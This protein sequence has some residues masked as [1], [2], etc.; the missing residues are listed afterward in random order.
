M[1]MQQDA[2]LYLAIGHTT[3]CYFIFSKWAYSALD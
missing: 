2:M 1:G 3:R